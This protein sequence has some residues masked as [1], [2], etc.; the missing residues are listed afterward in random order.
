MSMFLYDL[1]D[2]SLLTRSEEGQLSTIYQKGFTVEIATNR[3][4]QQLH[5]EPTH[6][7]LADALTGELQGLSAE[8]LYQV[9]L[10]VVQH[11][12]SAHQH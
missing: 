6:A 3:L 11:G 8:A 5:R 2:S 12:M 7:E 4:T 10:V 9:S 1:G